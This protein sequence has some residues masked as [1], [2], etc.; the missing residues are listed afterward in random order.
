MQ[1]LKIIWGNNFWL[2]E[3]FSLNEFWKPSLCN[4]FVAFER[5]KAVDYFRKAFHHRYLA[6][7]SIRLCNPF[8]KVSF[9]KTNFS[10]EVKFCKFSSLKKKYLGV[11]CNILFDCAKT[12]CSLF[13]VISST[14]LHLRF[15]IFQPLLSIVFCAV[16]CFLFS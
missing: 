11:I 8:R 13:C 15:H 16:T 4:V 6:G 7:F 12:S 2:I 5:L 14:S 10:T 1:F 3:I 9:H